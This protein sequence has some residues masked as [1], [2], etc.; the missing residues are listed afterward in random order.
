MKNPKEELQDEF[1]EFWDNNK[2]V[3]GLG[4]YSDAVTNFW[5]NKLEI[6]NQNIA[7]LQQKLKELKGCSCTYN[8][9]DK[10]CYWHKY[11]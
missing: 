2:A 11:E 9:I 7:L 3:L 10:E 6:I 1:M 5:L 8:D 4:T